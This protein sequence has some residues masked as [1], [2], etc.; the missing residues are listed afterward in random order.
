AQRCVIEW[1]KASSQAC[2]ACTGH[3]GQE[4]KLYHYGASQSGKLL[5]LQRITD[6]DLKRYLNLLNRKETVGGNTYSRSYGNACDFLINIRPDV[7]YVASL[8]TKGDKG[9]TSGIPVVRRPLF[10]KGSMEASVQATKANHVQ[11]HG[12]LPDHYGRIS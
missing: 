5:H 4:L 1:D 6:A 2:V 11:V 10:I 9:L 8:Q 3:V 7:N 12:E